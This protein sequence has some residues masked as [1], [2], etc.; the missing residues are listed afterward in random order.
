[1]VALSILK[2]KLR[3]LRTAN[4]M[5]PLLNHQNTHF[6]KN[7]KNIFSA[8]NSVYFWGVIMSL[9]GLFLSYYTFTN[10]F[11]SSTYNFWCKNFLRHL[12]THSTKG[13]IH[14]W[15][16]KLRNRSTQI[17]ATDLWQR[18]KGNSIE[19][20]WSFQ[21]WWCWYW[22]ST[23]QKKKPKTVDLTHFTKIN[24]KWVISLIVKC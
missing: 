22:I 10:C 17:Q 9:Y 11:T 13:Q 15:N 19:K 20:G 3:S 4:S 18:R 7:W 24:S 14:Q 23:H 5:V 21:K 16:R 2:T 6:F 8:F 12:K 1:M